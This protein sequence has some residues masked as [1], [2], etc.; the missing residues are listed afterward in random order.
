MAVVEGEEVGPLGGGG[1]GGVSE[2]G[3]GAGVGCSCVSCGNTRSQ[4][5][6]PPLPVFWDSS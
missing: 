1:A 5:E 3:R 6:Q 4:H 2:C